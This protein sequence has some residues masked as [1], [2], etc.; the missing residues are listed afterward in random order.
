M[1]FGL[2]LNNGIFENVDD[3]RALALTV[4]TAQLAEDLGYD[5]LWLTE[6]HFI[7]YGVCPS[8]ITLAGFLLGRT[9]RIRVGTAVTLAPLVH[10]I[11]LAEQVALNDQL[12]GG[13]FDLGLG[14]GGYSLDY[15]VFGIP[16]MRWAT[17]VE[18]TLEAVIDAL[19]NE[20][21][22]STNGFFAYD[23]VSIRPRPRTRPHPPIFI[24]SR[25]PGAVRAAAASRLPL[26]FNFGVE[27]EPR[28]ETADQYREFAEEAGWDGAAPH[29]HNVLC[30]VDDDEEAARERLTKGLSHSY[31][32]GNHP[33][34]QHPPGSADNPL[35]NRDAIAAEIVRR[36]PV[37][38]PDVVAAGLREFASSV[39]ATKLALY[40][41]ADGDPQRV[42]TSV[43]RFAEGVMPRLRDE[44]TPVRAGTGSGATQA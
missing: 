36:S 39:G 43:R 7:D 32:T 27:A 19:S 30:F 44:R 37:G 17:E 6:H 31:R 42:L 28:N 16:P 23:T 11:A 35:A 13:R 2:F 4:E 9:N 38:P 20:E 22:R 29:L 14:R 12:S 1:Q 41:E 24:A 40:M 34:L 25:S 33:S 10:P 8:A 5:E 18:A 21:T 3:Q 26:Q 15:D